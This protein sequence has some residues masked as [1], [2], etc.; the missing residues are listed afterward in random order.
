MC[1]GMGFVFFFLTIMICTMNINAKILNFLGK[2]FPEE[3]E[4]EQTPSKKKSVNNNESE[5]A[6]AIACAIAAA[7]GGKK[8]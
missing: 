2:Y 8:C 6:L 5:I 7:K 3:V 4:E 1:I